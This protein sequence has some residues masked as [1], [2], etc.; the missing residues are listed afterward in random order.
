MELNVEVAQLFL[1][2]LHE[3]LRSHSDGCWE[4]LRAWKWHSCKRPHPL[5]LDGRC[6]DSLIWQPD[7]PVCFKLCVFDYVF[8]MCLYYEM[9]FFFSFHLYVKPMNYWHAFIQRFYIQLQREKLATPRWGDSAGSQT[10]HPNTPCRATE[11]ATP[12]RYSTYLGERIFHQ[13]C[14]VVLRCMSESRHDMVKCFCRVTT[15]WNIKIS[16][17]SPR[18]LLTCEVAECRRLGS[19][20]YMM[21]FGWPTLHRRPFARIASD[22]RIMPDSKLIASLHIL[23]IYL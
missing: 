11:G 6:T 22:G 3:Y 13:S 16:E 17:I 14:T 19:L 4:L 5:E 18:D 12:C 15:H 2:D 21:D 20:F 9:I 7:F 1:H 23:C 10:G 8:D